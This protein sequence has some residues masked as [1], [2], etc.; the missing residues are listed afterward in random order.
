MD[1]NN[2]ESYLN[3]MFGD[4]PIAKV[5]VNDAKNLLTGS[6]DINQFNNKILELYS[7]KNIK[8]EGFMQTELNKNLEDILNFALN[9]YTKSTESEDESDE[10]VD[11]D[12][13]ERMMLEGEDDEQQDVEQQDDVDQLTERVS[14]IE[15]E[16]KPVGDVVESIA[17]LKITEPEGTEPEGTEPEGTEPE[18]ESIESEDEELRGLVTTKESFYIDKILMILLTNLWPQ[19]QLTEDDINYKTVCNSEN[20]RQSKKILK[21]VEYTLTEMQNYI[22]NEEGKQ[23]NN[24]AKLIKHLQESC[25]TDFSK[26]RGS[27]YEFLL[28]FEDIMSLNSRRYTSNSSKISEGM[29]FEVPLDAT[30]EEP[31][32]L[33]TQNILSFTKG[34]VTKT[35]KSGKYVM[36][37]LNRENA[38]DRPVKVKKEITL[39]R[40]SLEITALVIGDNVYTSEDSIWYK[41]SLKGKGQLKQVSPKLIKNKEFADFICY[42]VIEE[43]E[44]ESEDESEISDE[45]DEDT[46]E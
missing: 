20:I 29:S 27:S 11:A 4:D 39:G 41:Y 19:R 12:E 37:Y 23:I 46:D 5:L 26:I 1:I 3:K 25:P 6:D 21:E 15:I 31:D 13:L 40:E 7:S 8:M 14:S 30:F 33:T 24:S 9:A 42:S 22:V 18:D 28:F 34:G 43:E 38:I 32:N 17:S 2:Y 16:D 36:L 44:T 35:L 10:S 45:S